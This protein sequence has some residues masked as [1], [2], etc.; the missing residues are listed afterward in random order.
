MQKGVFNR[1]LLSTALVAA[2]GVANALPASASPSSFSTIQN[3]VIAKLTR[4]QQLTDADHSNP[5][6]IIAQKKLELGV[7]QSIS[8]AALAIKNA[9][10]NKT[11]TW[12]TVKS[13]S[14]LAIAAYKTEGLSYAQN[15]YNDYEQVVNDHQTLLGEQASL[16]AYLSANASTLVTDGVY[17][18]LQNWEASGKQ[19]ISQ[20]ETWLE[21]A[22]TYFN[23][24]A[25]NFQT[26]V[27]LV[28]YSLSIAGFL[29]SG[30]EASFVAIAL[31]SASLGSCFL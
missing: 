17:A 9:T 21:D 26:S 28:C 25:S 22:A 5:G 10:L 2:F 30:P 19:W 11:A 8:A 16:V 27:N 20:D 13:T 12:K 7:L 31:N 6:Q 15:A 29:V 14:L 24:P 23:W 1:V 3:T 4:M 18:D